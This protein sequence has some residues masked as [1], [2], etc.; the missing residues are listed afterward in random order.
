PHGYQNYRLLG[1]IVEEP[2]NR[3]EQ[4]GWATQANDRLRPPGFV[5]FHAFKPARKC[6]AKGSAVGKSVDS[7]PCCGQLRS[8]LQAG[9]NRGG[10]WTP[11]YSSHAAKRGSG[12]MPVANQ[13][14]TSWVRL[15]RHRRSHEIHQRSATLAVSPASTFPR[16]R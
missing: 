10:S 11:S 16:A 6:G 4:F 9:R 8:V 12:R 7:Y 3:G 5:A 14:L 13:D 1:H 2:R 15:E